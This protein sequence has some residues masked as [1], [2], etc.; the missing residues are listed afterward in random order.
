RD[1]PFRSFG[2]LVT[3][4]WRV[5]RP[6]CPSRRRAPRVAGSWPCTV[7]GREGIC[8]SLSARGG[9][10]ELPTPAPTA[11]AVRV[12]IGGAMGD[13]GTVAVQGRVVQAAAARTAREW[14]GADRGALAAVAALVASRGTPAV[15]A[16]RLRSLWGRPEALR[17]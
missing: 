17:T 5:T 10:F 7:G 13:H 2:Y 3:T 15:R 9:L 1:D 6:R 8:V 11:V 12:E 16:S 4:L 14:D